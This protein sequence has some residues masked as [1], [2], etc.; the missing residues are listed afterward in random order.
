MREA[1]EVVDL[2]LYIY[3]YYNTIIY[4][5]INSCFL[6]YRLSFNCA[7]NKTVE[8]L[9]EVAINSNQ[10]EKEGEVDPSPVPHKALSTER[11]NTKTV[12]V[13][14]IYIY[15]YIIC[16]CVWSKYL[17]I[18]YF[19]MLSLSLSLLFL[20]FLF[21]CIVL[22]VYAWMHFRVLRKNLRPTIL[23]NITIMIVQ[24]RGG[25]KHHLQQLRLL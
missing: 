1:Q 12:R 19:Q 5:V 6:F 4:M 16:L 22:Y 20:I 13:Y 8:K 10:E 18:F 7:P 9:R 14:I 2:P 3:I 21:L 17:F 23:N 15:I 11:R 25:R 24:R